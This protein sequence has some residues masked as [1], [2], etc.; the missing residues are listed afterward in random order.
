MVG[1]GRTERVAQAGDPQPKRSR[2]GDLHVV[3]HDRVDQRDHERHPERREQP[4]PGV[5]REG[6]ARPPPPILCPLLGNPALQSGGSRGDRGLRHRTEAGS[7]SEARHGGDPSGGDAGDRDRQRGRPRAEHARARERQL[8]PQHSRGRLEPLASRT[9]IAKDRPGRDRIARRDDH[10]K[11]DRVRHRL[12]GERHNRDRDEV[13]KQFRQR[14]V[15]HDGRRLGSADVVPARSQPVDRRRDGHGRSE[16]PGVASSGEKPQR[17]QCHRVGRD[18]HG[19]PRDDRGMIDLLRRRELLA[20]NAMRT[21][22]RPR[23][24]DEHRCSSPDREPVGE[25]DPAALTDDA[26]DHGQDQQRRHRVEELKQPELHQPVP[27]EGPA[28][29]TLSSPCRTTETK[30]DQVNRPAR[31][32]AAVRSGASHSAHCRASDCAGPSSRRIA[33]SPRTSRLNG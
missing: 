33:L 13:G 5:D 17:H 4:E 32:R 22:D 30:L 1:Q 7:S 11:D 26:D 28:H 6:L 23:Q 18:E 12:A 10:E 25:V 8:A 24:P 14:L 16:R 2:P 29:Q 20:G 15:F 31:S 3:E 9:A 27:G 21:G 19:A